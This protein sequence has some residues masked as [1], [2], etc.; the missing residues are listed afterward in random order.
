VDA[1]EESGEAIM[2]HEL[3]ERR[4]IEELEKRLAE[5][6]KMWV[7]LDKLLVCYRIGKQASG[8]L[9]DDIGKQRRLLAGDD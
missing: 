5:H 1:Q 2:A 3:M 8:K 6:R 7:L 9:L 4:I